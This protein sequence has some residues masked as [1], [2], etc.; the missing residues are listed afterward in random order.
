MQELVQNRSAFW[1]WH[2]A[3]VNQLRAAQHRLLPIAHQ[4]LVFGRW[5]RRAFTVSN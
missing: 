4:T 5:L 3:A 1:Q 2:K